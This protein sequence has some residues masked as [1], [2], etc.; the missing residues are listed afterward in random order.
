[1]LQR[2]QIAA[3]RALLEW[4]RADLSDAS[5]VSLRTIARFESGEGD[6][7]VSKLARLERALT[8]AGIRFV[9]GGAVSETLLRRPPL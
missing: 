7:T 2:Q 1:M 4:S 5:G 6:V 8:D 9:D 3:G